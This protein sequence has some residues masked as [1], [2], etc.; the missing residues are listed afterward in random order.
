MAS[1][2]RRENILPSDYYRGGSSRAIF[3]RK[4]D[5]PAYERPRPSIFLG[6]IGSPDLNGKQLDGV[7]GG[8]SSLSKVCIVG[9]SKHPDV[10]WTIRL[11]P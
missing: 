9:P 7:G 3:F 2:Y 1:T 5:L 10:T 6:T 11:F 4:Q 8:I